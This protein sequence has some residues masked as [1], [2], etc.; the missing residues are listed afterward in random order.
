[1]S[2]IFCLTIIL[3][4]LMLAV[5][6]KKGARSFFALVINF[7]IILFTVILMLNPHNDPILITL[8]ASAGIS[9]INL[10]YINR[11]SSKT[12]TAFFST[13]ITIAILL[14]LIY[15]I[16]KKA[17]VQGF[18]EEEVDELSVFN[19]FIAVNFQKVAV[20]MIIMSTI[21]A[22]TD[23]AIAV[24]SPMREIFSHHPHMNRQEL[25]KSGMRVGRDVL[26]SDANTL[27][28]A[29]I[30]GYIAL[31]IWFRDLSYSFGEIVNSKVFG[32]EMLSI[33]CAGIGIAIIV[34]IAAAMN[35]WY[36]T[37][38]GEKGEA[39]SKNKA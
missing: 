15:F 27:F 28:F 10:F 39:E 11:I 23:I 1:M 30:G 22:I 32:A 4:V 24:T 35:A 17:M 9:A 31:I 3:F 2:T 33:F 13:L 12:G 14:P 16:M 19:F 18:G 37:R 29:F 8:M 26:G 38:K 5:G 21:G 36:L 25:F 6:G 7:G 34:P 20:S